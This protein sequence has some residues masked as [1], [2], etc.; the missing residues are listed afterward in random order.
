MGLNNP[1]VKLVRNVKD[2]YTNKLHITLKIT[3]YY[4]YYLDIQNFWEFV[5]PYYF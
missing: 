1:V 3:D 4:I 5:S 2:W